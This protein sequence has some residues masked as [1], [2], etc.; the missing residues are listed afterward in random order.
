[1]RG[2]LAYEWRRITTVRST[3]WF[4][5]MAIGCSAVIAFFIAVAFSR[6]DLTSDGVSTFLEAS[7]LVITAGGSVFIV[8]VITAAFCGV[9]GAMAFGHEYRYGTIKQT[10]T[11]IPDRTTAFFAKLLVLIGWLTVLML[12]VV[13]VN[14]AMGV[15]FLTGFDLGGEAVRPIID[16]V[17]Y[18]VGFGIAGFSLAAVFRNLAGALVAVLVYPFV[19]E[20]IGYN[21]VRFVHTGTVDRVANLFPAAAGRRTI[22]SPYEAFANPTSSSSDTVLHVWGLAAST[23]V[24]W[25]GLLILLGVALGL[26]LRRDA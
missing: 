10:L 6:A 5:G 12:V 7:T 15:L 16:F 4:S 22:F 19:L 24:F 25:C 11:A 13:L 14:M 9:L 26:F 17:L 2:A 23:A 8:P 18:N 1:M 3:L 21:I 20:N